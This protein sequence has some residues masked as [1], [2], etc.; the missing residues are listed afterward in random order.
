MKAFVA[1]PFNPKFLPVWKAIR[2]ACE[3]NDISACRV[4]QLPQ[5]GDILTTIYK[6]IETADIIIVDFS[7][8]KHPESPNANVV[9][10]ATYA[11]TKK[12]PTVIMTQNVQGL[13]F[14]WKTYRAVVY[15][16]SPSGLEYLAEVLGENLA[17]VKK[18][19]AGSPVSHVTSV[20]RVSANPKHEEKWAETSSDGRYK[21]SRVGVILDTKTNLEWFVGLDED[22]TWGAAKSWTDSLTVDG[23]G[24]RM[25]TIEE[26]RGLY[27]KGKGKGNMDQVFVTTDSS[28]CC[29][30]SCEVNGIHARIFTFYHGSDMLIA[31]TFFAD[32]IRG[33]AVRSGRR[34]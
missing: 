23:G 13:P 31:R 10:E 2:R 11:R 7:G 30:W 12:K 4:D 1:M 5:V 34:E 22:T 15:E 25:P 32:N 26:L 8:D 19:L 9:T 17:G 14:D 21:K 6:E 33:F 3:A 20:P 27:Q 16:N 29:I 28:N 24:W 18:R